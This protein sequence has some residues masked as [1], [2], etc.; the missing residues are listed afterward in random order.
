MYEYYRKRIRTLSPHSHTQITLATSVTRP[1]EETKNRKNE[2]HL[3]KKEEIKKDDCLEFL[4][5]GTKKN[6]AAAYFT[7]LPRQQDSK[8]P[9]TYQMALTQ[10]M[11]FFWSVGPIV[12]IT[13]Y[14]LSSRTRCTK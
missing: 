13:R 11:S 10:F 7:Q 4:R 12:K 2:G 8:D 1:Y 6:V 14:K 3:C 5:V 9:V